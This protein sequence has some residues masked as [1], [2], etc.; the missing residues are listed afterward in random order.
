M[1][2]SPVTPQDLSASVLAVPPLARQAD[3]SLDPAANRALIRHLEAGGVS[4]LMYGGNAN[5]YNLGVGDYAGVL[6]LLEA[7]AAAESWVI[8]SIG[9]AFGIAMDQAKILRPRAFPT[10]MALPMAAQVTPEGAEAGLARVAEAFGRPL[11]VYIKSDSYL[12]P[13][14]LARLARSGAVAAVKYAVER[15]AVS[16]D[17]YLRALIDAIGADRIV[18][19][20]GELPGVAHLRAFGLAAFT[21][22]SVCIAPRLSTAILA[23]CRRGDFAAAERLR[24]AFVPLESL[25]NELSQ[26]RVLHEAVRLAGVAETGPL[27]PH[28]SNIDPA[29]HAAIGAAARALL[30]ADRDLPLAA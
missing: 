7:E 15:P 16:P 30:A 4:T 6:D 12:R 8:P 2:T 13:E 14:G 17:P 25:R 11:I 21:S 9:P 18:S 26:I 22:G 29:H 23:A 19:G 10:A 3:L 1:K 20:M 24:A 27:L 5:F 28:L